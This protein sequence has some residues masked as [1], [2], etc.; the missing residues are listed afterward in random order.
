MGVVGAVWS[1]AAGSAG[2]VVVAREDGG[3]GEEEGSGEGIAEDEADAMEGESEGEDAAGAARVERLCTTR[4]S[5][6]ARIRR[7]SVPLSRIWG[8]RAGDM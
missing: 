5:A 7:P 6:L 3:G 4:S 1:S 2:S 8:G